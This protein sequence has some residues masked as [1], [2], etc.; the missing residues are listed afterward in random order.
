MA[1]YENKFEIG[2][3]V[4]FNHLGNQYSGWYSLVKLFGVEVLSACDRATKCIIKNYTLHT[5]EHNKVFVYLLEDDDKN[6]YLVNDEAIELYNGQD[7]EQT[8]K[9]EPHKE[10]TKT[11]YVKCDKFNRPCSYLTEGKVYSVKDV[12]GGH[13]PVIINDKG[14]E[15]WL[16]TVGQPDLHTGS[17]WQYTTE[18]EY[19]AQQSQKQQYKP[20]SKWVKNTGEKPDLPDG[21]LVKV[22]WSDGDIMEYKVEDSAWYFSDKPTV[23]ILKWKL[24]DDWNKVVDGQAPDIDGETRIDVKWK[25]SPKTY[26]EKKGWCN[27]KTIKAWRYAKEK[28]AK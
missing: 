21:T 14:N 19:L 2:D 24:A 10:V 22:K 1:I 20:R 3:V 25:D 28:K 18:E 15:T 7:K 13:T 17:V 11:G 12:K 9:S 16:A 4:W 6:I 23:N 26:N 27:F 8:C 5:N